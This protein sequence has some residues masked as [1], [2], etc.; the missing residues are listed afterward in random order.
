LRPGTFPPA[1]PWLAG[2]TLPYYYWGFV[3]WVLP[4]RLLRLDPDVAYNI[5]VPT[6][7]AVAAQLGW[8]LAR[9]LGGGR[10]A[11]WLAATL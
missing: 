8:G 9:A 3:P 10:R 5:L 4:A 7:A 1:D 6:L 11:A 2:F